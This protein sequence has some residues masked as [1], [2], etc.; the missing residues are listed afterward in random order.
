ME[1]TTLDSKYPPAA[2]RR[3]FARRRDSTDYMDNASKFSRRMETLGLVDCGIDDSSLRK[4]IYPHVKLALAAMQAAI[5]EL[6]SV[7]PETTP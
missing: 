6:H 5:T 2:G 7:S 4:Q 3:V 1:Y